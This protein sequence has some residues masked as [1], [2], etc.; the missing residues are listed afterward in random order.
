ML[1]NIY[2]FGLMCLAV[3][4]AA[5]TP[6]APTSPY[7]TIEEGQMNYSVGYEKVAKADSRTFTVRSNKS[8]EIVG[9][10]QYDWLKPFPSRGEGDGRFYFVIDENM[11]LEEREA[12]YTLVID[13]K[14]YPTAITVTQA[15]RGEFVEVSQKSFTVLAAESKVGL[16]VKTNVDVNYRVISDNSGANGSWISFPKTAE[17]DPDSLYIKVTQSTQKPPRTAM[18]AIYMEGKNTVADTVTLMQIGNQELYG[19]PAKWTFKGKQNDERFKTGWE[20][21]NS[22]P[23]DE[24]LGTF[25]YVTVEPTNDKYVRTVGSTGDPYLNGAWPGDYWL[26]EVPAIIPANTMFQIT[27]A[28]RVSDTGHK[29]WCLEYLDGTE[30]LPVGTL[31]TTSEPGTGV[32]Y[33][34][35]MQ[36][37]DQTIS[38]SFKVRNPMTT[39]QIRYRCAANWTAGNATTPSAAL[40]ARNGG[41]AR[42]TGRTDVPLEIKILDTN[43][44]DEAVLEMSAY[45]VALEGAAGSQGSI[46]IKSSESWTLTTTATWFEISQT[47]GNAN[48]QATVTV[49]AKSA[50]T[51]GSLR[52]ANITLKSGLTTKTIEVIQG[53]ASS[54]STTPEEP[55]TPVTPPASSSLYAEWLFTEEGAVS[56]TAPYISTFGGMDP[57]TKSHAEGDGGLYVMSDAQGNGKLTYVQVDKT[58][59]T[60]IK[61]SRY[62]GSTGHPVITGAWPGDYW[63]F[64]ATDGK[65]YP[66][67]TKLQIKFETRISGTG[68]LYWML[69]YWDGQAWKPTETPKSALLGTETVQYN[70]IPS[71]DK[72]NNSKVDFTWSLAQACTNLMF[73]S[74]CVANF[75]KDGALDAPNGGTCRIAGAAGTSPVFKV[76]E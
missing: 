15:T 74:R 19:F 52:K 22:V 50:N 30:W 27:F 35:T 62:I 31:L 43:A 39:L 33:T 7:F 67:G 1:K 12:V 16:K 3:V 17:M 8:W 51:T 59:Y 63:L 75:N 36:N 58:S 56:G 38:G 42:M 70:L 71:T 72:Y 69:E 34:H 45:H 23:S 21:L 20:T 64:E 9:V 2:K 44:G 28:G 73:R 6:E 60:S 68:Q 32:S 76:V 18:I 25:K 48:V 49:K 5:C 40:S 47:Q 54:G 53:A 41:S 13:G 65:E 61:A 26:Y 24:G 4:I 37:V 29:F 11:T 66:A 46:K 55:D 10:D 57:G 14:E